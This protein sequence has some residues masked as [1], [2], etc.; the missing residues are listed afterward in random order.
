MTHA[1][2]A[3]SHDVILSFSRG[4]PR[5]HDVILFF[6][7]RRGR[8]ALCH[9]FFFR[10]AACRGHGF[11]PPERPSGNAKYD[12]FPMFYKHIRQFLQPGVHPMTQHPNLAG[13]P[14]HD[15]ILF[16]R[17]AGLGSMMSYFPFDRNIKNY[18]I[19]T[20][21]IRRGHDVILFFWPAK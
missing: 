2:P 17:R 6:W 4:R 3:T 10:R 1:Q 16:F 7:L 8:P 9:T 20:W 19:M 21:H 15:V 18:D 14:G 5:P 13:W 12:E 11:D